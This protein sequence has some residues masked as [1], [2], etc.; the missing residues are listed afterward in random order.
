MSNITIISNYYP[1]EIGAASNRIYNMAQAFKQADFD[2][3]VICP[4]P[5]YPKGKIFDGYK[6]KFFKKESFQGIS[7][8]RL[9]IYPTNSKSS[10]KRILSMLSFAIS[11]WLIIFNRKLIKNS[12]TILIQNSPLL[13][14]F[15]SLLLFKFLLKR[16][17]ILNVSD[18]WP[19]SAVDIGLIKPGLV[20]NLLQKIEIFN[21]KNSDK[22][23]CQSE[24]I[25]TFIL[26]KIKKD[27]FIYRNIQP[28]YAPIK[29][30]TNRSTKVRLVYAG[31]LGVAQGIFELINHIDTV[32][33]EFTIDIYGDGNEKEIIN[34]YLE[35]NNDIK[36]KGYLSKVEL[37]NN[38]QNYDFALVP[39]VK[40]IEGA[41]PSKI[42]ELVKLGIPIIYI[43]DGE[44]FDFIKNN[45]L[46][47]AIKSG[48]F[49]QLQ[50]VLNSL[51]K[52]SD[53][54]INEFKNNCNRVNKELLNFNSQFEILLNFI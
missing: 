30:H 10:F 17:V 35:I 20:L 31:L 12:E 25:E 3:N 2:V 8:N 16:K 28:D 51:N 34:R 22:I 52:I 9:F 54:Q 50:N 38:L 23:L 29:I 41:F 4:I 42:Y 39:L 47:F 5:N 44:A 27:S 19:K 13:V 32:G 53:N 33:Q 45:N 49:K 40:Y 46:G 1:P 21:Y 18:L 11:L 6:M 43:G 14:S 48:D 15:S 26:N 7:I 24:E 37:V 36:Y